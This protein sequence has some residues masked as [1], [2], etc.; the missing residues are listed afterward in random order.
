MFIDTFRQDSNGVFLPFVRDEDRKLQQVVAAA[1][2]GPSYWYMKA[3]EKELG[4]IGNRGGGKTHTMVLR[5]LSG[6][7]RGWGSHYNC[8]LLRSSLRE[9]T[10]LVAMVNGIVQPIWGK[11]VAFN[12]LAHVW[13]W[14]SGER[15]E[16]NYYIDDS[17]FE[18][19]Q[20]KNF[21]VV[22]FEELS[23]QKNLDGYMRMFSTLRSA[24]PENIMARHMLFTAN[25][26]GPSHNAIKHRFQLSGIPP[27]VGPSIVDENGE[28]RR[29][30]NCNYEDNALLRRSDPKYML[31]I[32]QSCEGDPP[33][34]QSWKFGNWDIVAGGALD[35]VFFK[36]GRYI[37]VESFEIPATWRTFASYDHGSSRPYAWLAWAESDGTDLMFKSGRVMSTRPG[38][39][40]LVGEVYGNLHGEPDKGSQRE[41]RGNHYPRSAVQDQYGMA[42]PRCAAT[43]QVA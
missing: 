14:K 24:L 6:V 18:L 30:F 8:V 43:E 31:T 39:L 33:R 27:A 9:M 11:S 40:F 36:Y 23:L 2:P 5:L 41:R 22:A 29:A 4:L 19:Y 7:G 35:D 28:S 15:L 21:A 17:S 16:L 38:D 42:L 26:G 32:E 13:E 10:D 12:K 20:G 1:Q 37:Y 3:P 34:L 25:P